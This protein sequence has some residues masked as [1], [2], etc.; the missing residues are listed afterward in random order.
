M[1]NKFEDGVGDCYQK[2]NLRFNPSL[3]LSSMLVLH[4]DAHCTGR[5]QRLL[6]DKKVDVLKKFQIY[7]NSCCQYL[8]GLD[9]IHG[10]SGCV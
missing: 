1:V 10:I 7:A 6:N 9:F 2:I 3:T 8:Q 5:P 4:A